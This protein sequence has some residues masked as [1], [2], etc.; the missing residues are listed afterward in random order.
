[1][2][3]GA[4]CFTG[5]L[6]MSEQESFKSI[7][8]QKAVKPSEDDVM[9][10]MSFDNSFERERLKFNDHLTQGELFVPWK[11]YK[12]PT[13]GDIEIGGWVK[14]SSRLPHPFMLKDMCHRN[15]AT[16]IF[17]AKHTP[18]VSLKVFEIKRVGKNL[19]RLRTRLKNAKAIPTMT[20][21]V[22]KVKLYPR[23]IL[24]VSGKGIKVTA[25]GPLRDV[26]RD[27]VAYKEF[28]P[29]THFLHVPGFGKVEHQFLISGKKGSKVT[30]KY[31]S[32]HAGKISKTIE[33][34]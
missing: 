6:F 13:Y 25:G 27:Q 21:H 26:H 32:R 5:E 19:Y 10:F 4:Y 24:T 17:S 29:E 8:E 14:M 28:R 15:A 7:K 18:E 20:G 33:L 22:R 3:I 11:P 34:K 9:D 12:H 31:S 16:I 1:M 23:D 30:I 2:S